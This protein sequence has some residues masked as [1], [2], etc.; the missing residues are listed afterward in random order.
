MIGEYAQAAVYT[1]NLAISIYG[2]IY[3]GKKP[4]PEAAAHAVESRSLSEKIVHVIIDNTQDVRCTFIV[5]AKF[6][7]AFKAAVNETE[8]AY[9]AAYVTNIFFEKALAARL[10]EL[11]I[12]Y[13]S[14]DFVEHYL[15]DDIDGIGAN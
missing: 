6:T 11:G 10:D 15:E 9:T 14:P 2:F 13:E 1:A 8:A 12:P 7:A 4:R 5:P 3:W